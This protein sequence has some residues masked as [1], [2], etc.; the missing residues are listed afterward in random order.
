MSESREHVKTIFGK[1]LEIRSEDE[2][3]K[4][5]DQACAGDESL[6][7]EVEDLLGAIER[8][9]NFLGGSSPADPT[10][11]HPIAEK[12]GDVIGPYKLLQQ[13]GEGGFGVVYMAEQTEP[14]TRQVA[15]KIIKP[16]MDT[17]EVIARFE[18]ERQALAM[19]NHPVLLVYSGG[20]D[21]S[22]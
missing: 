17:K 11:A 19:M 20:T 18:S 1:A 5:L 10:L 15:L 4:Y 12:P 21:K 2:R 8:A 22:C 14:V 13:I 6:R 16:G 9:G 7:A 3:A